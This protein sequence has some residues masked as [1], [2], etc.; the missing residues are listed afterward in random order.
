M[1]QKQ[2][3]R[4]RR[5]FTLIE[6]LVVVAIIALL[7]SILLPALGQARKQAR[8]VKCGAQLHDIGISL[9]AYNNEFRRFPHQNSVGTAGQTRSQREGYGFWSF[10]VHQEIA[11]HM[12]GLALNEDATEATRTHPVFYCPFALPNQIDFANVLSGPGTPNGIGNTEEV[13]LHISYAYMGALHEVAND[14]A[15]YTDVNPS[16]DP[17][18]RDQILKK[19]REYVR[20]EPDARYVLMADMVSGWFGGA[21]WRVNHGTGW[22]TSIM[23]QIPPVVETS[24]VLFGDGHVEQKRSSHY[25]ELTGTRNITEI[26]RNATL[27]AGIDLLWW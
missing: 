9:N 3:Q 21:K 20:K 15:N 17:L 11:R 25:R 5:G 6:L 1:D 12:G 23:D 2:C 19:R 24:N 26:R 27:R 18:L 10:T 4:T 7:I 14:P 22:R 8:V 16:T 13:Y